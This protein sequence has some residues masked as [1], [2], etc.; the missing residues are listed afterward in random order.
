[1]FERMIAALVAAS[2]R[3]VVIGGVAAAVHGSARLTNDL[4][5]CY[6]TAPDNVDR[7]IAVLRRWRAYLRAVEP[8]LPFILDARALSATPVMT[9]TTDVGDIDIVDQVAG[10]GTY[11]DTVAASERVTIGATRFRVLTLPALVA[12]KRAAGRPRDIEHLIELEALLAMR[13]AAR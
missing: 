8:G 11:A 3:F 12:A 13:G 5:I 4:D 2:V 10:V 7:L 9:L 1:M 6:D